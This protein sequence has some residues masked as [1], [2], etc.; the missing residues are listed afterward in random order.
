MT[1]GTLKLYHKIV[2]IA[3]IDDILPILMRV[4]ADGRLDDHRFMDDP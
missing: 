1:A 4:A 3:R 2:T